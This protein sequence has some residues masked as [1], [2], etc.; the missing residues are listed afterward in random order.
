MKTVY[1]ISCLLILLSFSCKKKKEP[2]YNINT[3]ACGVKNP[4]ENLTWLN[5]KFKLFTGAAEM[6]SI[7]L[8]RYEDKEMIEIKS[9]VSS[10]YPGHNYYCYGAERTFNQTEYKD[11]AAKRVKLAVLYGKYNID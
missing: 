1:T 8:Y 11:Y 3:M 4:L 2:D 9:A 7:V 6:T 5:E 10:Y